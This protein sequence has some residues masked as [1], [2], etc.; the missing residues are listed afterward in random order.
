MKTST[1][2][3][4]AAIAG[5]LSVGAVVKT[6]NASPFQSSNILM[7]AKNEIGV[8]AEKSDGDGETNDDANEQQENAK[9]QSLAKVTP[10][11][12]KKAAETSTGASASSVKL[13]NEDGNLVYAVAIG[14]QE[15]K[16]DA[17][18]GKVLY[19]ENGEGNETNETSRPKSSIQV[20]QS[21]DNESE[22][23]ERGR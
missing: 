7:M 20:P 19:T 15:V 12:A 13:E 23:N 14:K 21:R 10:E 11:Q 1:K 3:A 4:L 9:L 8:K 16:V 5:V 17:G 18:N 22:G 2:I 6:V